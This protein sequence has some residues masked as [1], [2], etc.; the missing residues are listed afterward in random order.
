VPFE[1]EDII[2]K[3]IF[4]LPSN[5]IKDGSPDG[6]L[7]RHPEKGIALTEEGW[8]EYVSWMTSTLIA[9]QAKQ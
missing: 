1:L 5:Q 4:A 7:R 6:I 8:S 3:W 9:A 2:A